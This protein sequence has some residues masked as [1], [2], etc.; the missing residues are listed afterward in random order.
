MPSCGVMS[1]YLSLSLSLSLSLC[2]CLSRSWTVSKRINVAS[3]FFNRRVATPRH[4]NIQAGTPIIRASNAG[5]IGRNR[6]SEPISG[7]TACVTAATAQV[8]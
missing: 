6:D 1:V 7:L 4:S 5:G 2:V 8:L 3:K